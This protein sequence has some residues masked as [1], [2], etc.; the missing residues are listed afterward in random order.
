MVLVYWFTAQILYIFK[1]ILFF[2]P[3]ALF[4]EVMGFLMEGLLIPEIIMLTISHFI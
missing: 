2:Y 4:I 3:I 1:Q